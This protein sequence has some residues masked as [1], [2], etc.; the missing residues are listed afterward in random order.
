M[1]IIGMP[2]VGVLST[3]LLRDSALSPIFFAV[4]EQYFTGFILSFSVS[5]AFTD[6]VSYIR[7]FAVGLAGVAVANAFSQMAL[8]IVQ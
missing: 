6:I 7:L 8:S 5:S 1:M 4:E 3:S 2:L